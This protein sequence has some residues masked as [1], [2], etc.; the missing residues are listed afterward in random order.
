MYPVSAAN[1]IN[2]LPCRVKVFPTRYADT[3]STG[4]TRNWRGLEFGSTLKRADLCDVSARTIRDEHAILQSQYPYEPT[5][6]ALEVANA[7]TSLEDIDIIT[8]VDSL[9]KLLAFICGPRASETPVTQPFRLDLSSVR[10]TLF[11]LT[12]EKPGRGYTGPLRKQERRNSMN[13]VPQWAAPVL[14]RIGSDDPKLPCSGGHYRLVRYR[15]G[16]LVLAVREK[17]DFVHEHH[18]TSVR[19]F[20]EA[21]DGDMASAMSASTPS[22]RV[23]IGK[24]TVDFQGPGTHPDATGT[25]AVRYD[26]QRPLAK[27]N[28]MMPQLWFSRTRFLVEGVVDHPALQVQDASIVDSQQYYRSFERGHR[29]SLRHLAGLL[30]HLQRRTCEL[31]G[32]TVVICDPTQVCLVVLRPVIKTSPVPEDIVLKFWGPEESFIPIWALEK[33]A[34]PGSESDLTDLGTTPTPPQWFSFSDLGETATYNEPE[35]HGAVNCNPMLTELERMNRVDPLGW[36]G[37]WRANALQATEDDGY[38]PDVEDNISSPFTGGGDGYTTETD[39]NSIRMGQSTSKIPCEFWGA[40]DEDPVTGRE[41]GDDDESVVTGGYYQ[42]ESSP[43]VRAAYT[44]RT[45]DEGSRGEAIN[46]MQRH[47]MGII[48]DSEHARM[49]QMAM[50]SNG[51]G[52]ATEVEGNGTPALSS[53]K[54]QQYTPDNEHDLGFEETATHGGEYR[55]LSSSDD[56]SPA[57]TARSQQ[58]I[59]SRPRSASV[60]LDTNLR[61]AATPHMD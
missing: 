33:A 60:N 55:H 22:N 39:D 61:G 36:I 31:G 54:E 17:V 45:A 26:H 6:R 43:K 48:L 11:I 44:R 50:K 1:M 20:S 57:T 7:D 29:C 59:Q 21:P 52:M 14:N 25:A 2:S 46:Q 19:F 23:V 4:N 24:T 27:L 16:N 51:K 12:K 35:E 49:E 41:Q 3:E 30:R 53:R 56:R 28:E 37:D 10:N 38:E 8:D 32:N 47:H 18:S 40:S 9:T 58:M 13:T 42:Q 34:T 5:F 15:F